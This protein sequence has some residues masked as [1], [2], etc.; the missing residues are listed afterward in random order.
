MKPAAF[1][2]ATLSPPANLSPTSD[3][4]AVLTAAIRRAVSGLPTP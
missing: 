4:I 1:A 2:F 3:S